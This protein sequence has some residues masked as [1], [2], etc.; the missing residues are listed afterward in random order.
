MIAD[1]QFNRATLDCM[2]ALRRQIKRT[3]GVTIRLGDPD[4]VESMIGLS[5]D[6]SSAE[7]RELG[8][9]LA[10]MVKP[11]H[12]DGPSPLA[13][14]AIASRQFQHRQENIARLEAE[15]EA[16]EAPAGSV[17]IYRGQVI[18]G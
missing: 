17:R 14:G 3:L 2:T 7:I 15:S 9:R 16:G 18:R 13:Q 8:S 11:D 5:R 4:A 6:S 12:D 10:D 1:A